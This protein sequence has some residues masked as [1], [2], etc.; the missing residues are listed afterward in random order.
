MRIITLQQE[1]AY[2]FWQESCRDDK[3]DGVE[4]LPFYEWYSRYCS[5]QGFYDDCTSEQILTQN[6]LDIGDDGE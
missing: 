4:T 3:E 6:K 2:E 1:S 5:E